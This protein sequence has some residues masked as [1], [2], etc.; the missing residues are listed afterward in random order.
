MY[1]FSALLHFCDVV[2]SILVARSDVS[3]EHK[4][5]LVEALFKLSEAVNNFQEGTGSQ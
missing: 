1:V 4:H 2:A 3:D 5:E